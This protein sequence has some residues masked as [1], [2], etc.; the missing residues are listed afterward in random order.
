MKTDFKEQQK[1]IISKTKTLIVKVGSKLLL[2]DETVSYQRIEELVFNIAQLREKGLRVVLV[3]SGAISAGLGILKLKKRPTN[4]GDL[5]ALASLGQNYIISLYERACKKFHFHCGQV[6][7][8]HKTFNSKK[9]TQNFFY[10]LK[11]LFNYN[12]LPI[13]NENDSVATEEICFGDNDNLASIVAIQTKADLTAIY[14]NADGFLKTDKQG[15][16]SEVIH[17]INPNDPSL[18]KHILKTKNI[19]SKGG[20]ESKLMAAKKLKKH[21]QNILILNGN[22]FSNLLDF[23]DGKMIGTL[24]L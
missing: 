6:L 3:S 2:N 7:L 23:F 1:L 17:L 19:Y 18:K 13:I 20:I 12:I 24:C 14:T 11:S 15:N 8:T 10:C 16:F 21:K 5:Q 22:K 4:L 9:L